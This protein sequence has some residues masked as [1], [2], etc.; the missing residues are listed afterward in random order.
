MKPGSLRWYDVIYFPQVEDVDFEY[1]PDLYNYWT[2]NLTGLALGD[3]KQAINVTFGA[4]AVFDHASYGRGAALSVNAY[5]R[6]I[7]ISGATPVT[8]LDPWGV[9]NGNQTFYEIPCDKTEALP[10]I[11]YY[12]QGDKKPWVVVPSNYVQEAEGKCVF[13]VRTLGFGDMIAGNFGETFARDK[14]TVLDFQN[15]RVGL[16]DARF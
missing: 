6:L 11:K 12:F 8:L 16:A 4:G 14:V 15:L 10:E 13:N 2:L 7:E 9:N 5:K 3:E 1:T